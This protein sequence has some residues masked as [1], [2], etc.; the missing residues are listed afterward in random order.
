MVSV[1]AAGAI[2]I[3]GIRANRGERV[4]GFVDI[5]ETPGGPIRIPLVIVNG[6]RPGPVLCLTAGVHA[7]EYPPIDALMR[8]LSSLTPHALAGAVIAVPVANTA[9]FNARMPFVSPIDGLNLNMIA[10]GD[11]DGTISNILAY[12]LL[13]EII[14][15]SEYYIDIHGGD[16]GEMLLPFVAC[17]QTGRPEVD[18]RAEALARIYTPDLVVVSDGRSVFPFAGTIVHSAAHRGVVA[19]IAEAGG[20]GTMEEADVRVHLAGIQNVL[21]YL[22]MIDGAPHITGTRTRGVVQF[23]TRATHS[24]LLRLRVRIGDLVAAGQTVAEVC[25]VFGETVEV[26]R[27]AQSGTA[28]LIWAHR[29]VNTGDPIVRCWVTEPASPFP[30]TDRF[31][32]AN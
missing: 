21:R 1:A 20:N 27:V 19:V 12:V 32:V 7:T 29:V 9:M 3:R 17:L 26:V 11:R 4:Q 8:T 22:G 2:D 16:F 31:A 28:G 14:G 18:R 23:V 13:N 5:G 25:N 24:G 6:D 30:E 15:V 10:P